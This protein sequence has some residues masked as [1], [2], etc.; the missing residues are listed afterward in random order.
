MMLISVTE[1]VLSAK[2]T[3]WKLPD[4]WLLIPAVYAQATRLGEHHPWRILATMTSP[5]SGKALCR[6]VLSAT[7][8]H[9]CYRAS[10]VFTVPSLGVEI[11]DL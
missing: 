8:I 2:S 5:K 6:S 9:R 7:P 11:G 10:L 1:A 4:V 3:E